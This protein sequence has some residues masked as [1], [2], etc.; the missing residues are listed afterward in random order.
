MCA[1]VF[2]RK[3]DIGGLYYRLDISV[4]GRVTFNLIGGGTDI[5]EFVPEW[6]DDFVEFGM[7]DRRYFTN[8]RKVF[9]IVENIIME[10]LATNHPYILYFSANTKKK[11]RIYHKLASKFALKLTDYMFYEWAGVFYFVKKS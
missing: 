9:R 8:A 2:V 10:Y 1:I 3:F 7:R 4:S 6:N 5:N 11:R